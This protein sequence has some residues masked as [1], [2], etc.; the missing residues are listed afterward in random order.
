MFALI[1]QGN[2][3]LVKER[4]IRAPQL[5]IFRHGY[6]YRLVVYTLA[7]SHK[8]VSIVNIYGYHVCHLTID[9]RSIYF[10]HSVVNVRGNPD[11]FY[12]LRSYRL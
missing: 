11:I 1:Q 3:Q 5:E 8:R 9:Y 2:I 4:A 7:G 6:F 10:Q 12:M